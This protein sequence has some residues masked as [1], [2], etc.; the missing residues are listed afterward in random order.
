MPNVICNAFIGRR[1]KRGGNFVSSQL[2]LSL[3]YGLLASRMLYPLPNTN[4]FDVSDMNELHQSASSEEFKF[5]IADYDRVW[6]SRGITRTRD[7]I[8]KFQHL[9]R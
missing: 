4:S 6:G 8:E 7:V 2:A 9:R 5:A 3:V 1:R